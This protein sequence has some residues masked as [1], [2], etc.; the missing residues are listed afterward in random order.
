MC[1]IKQQPRSYLGRHLHPEQKI[2]AL[3][4]CFSPYVQAQTDNVAEAEVDAR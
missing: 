2:L 3:L 1:H 4:I